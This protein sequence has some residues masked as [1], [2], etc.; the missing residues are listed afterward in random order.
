MWPSCRASSGLGA[1]LIAL[2]VGLA[3]IGA[4][5]AAPAPAGQPEASDAARYGSCVALAHDKPQEA[6]TTAE[7][8]REESGGFPAEHCAALALI[9]LGRYPEA[10]RQ[11]EALA[12]AMMQE[13]PE[14]RAGALEQAGQAWLLADEAAR[15]KAA[16]DAALAF[17]PKDPDLLIDR[18]QAEAAA[19]QFWKALDDLNAALEI[20]PKRADALIYRAS[21]YRQLDSLDLALADV[22]Q[23]LKLSPDAVSGLL[24]RGNIR[25]L[26]GDLAGAGADWRRVEELAPNSSAGK[27][28]KDNLARLAA[29]TS[30][31]PA[32]N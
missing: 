10:A 15:A 17:E 22:E 3:G 20:A 6:L 8:W 21:T 9:G 7:S 28:A 31:G 2:L 5:A 12:G 4:A 11:L 23:A 27:A 26:K 30:A 24:E 19:K 25:R 32:R 16:F 14:L 13:K 1:L 18:A 29:E